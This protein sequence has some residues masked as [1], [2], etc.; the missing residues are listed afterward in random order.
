MAEFELR[1]FT[2]AAAAVGFIQ[3]AGVAMD[4]FRERYKSLIIGG[5]EDA[6]HEFLNLLSLFLCK[7]LLTVA[8]SVQPADYE[9]RFVELLKAIP[10]DSNSEDNT[11]EDFVTFCVNLIPQDSPLFLIGEEE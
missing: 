11:V 7:Y 8:E 9:R 10:I 6:R 5:E 3:P 1:N 4:M 2:A